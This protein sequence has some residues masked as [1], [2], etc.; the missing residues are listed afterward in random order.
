MLGRRRWIKSAAIAVLSLL[1]LHRTSAQQTGG[2][3]NA[4]ERQ[5][6]HH[7]VALG[8]QLKYGL[9]VVSPDQELYVQKVVALVDQGKLPKALVNLVYRWA[10][11]RNPSVPFPYFQYALRVLAK[12]QGV[13]IP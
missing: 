4:A 6:D 5:A 9:R 7:V 1:P 11:E 2:S 10:L 13:I 12:R 3:S 8:D